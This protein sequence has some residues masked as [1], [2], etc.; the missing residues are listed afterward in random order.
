VRVLLS[1]LIHSVPEVSRV[2]WINPTQPDEAP[3][4]WLE[5]GARSDARRRLGA[6]VPGSRR[7]PARPP[8]G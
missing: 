8:G 5:A 1:R 7:P 6:L 2:V 3:V 4:R